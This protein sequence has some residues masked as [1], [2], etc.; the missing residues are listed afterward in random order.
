MGTPLP[1]LNSN[2]RAEMA[3]SGITQGVLASRLDMSQSALSRRLTGD[4]D[5]TVEELLRTAEV[6]G[7]PIRTLL[8]EVAA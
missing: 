5:W 3:R 2:I 4:A 1:N 7:C 6:L 8:P